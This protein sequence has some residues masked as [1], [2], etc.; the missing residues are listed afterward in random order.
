[1]VERNDPA[2]SELWAESIRSSLQFVRAIHADSD[3]SESPAT[4]VCRI[5]TSLLSTAEVQTCLKDIGVFAAELRS[6]LGEPFDQ[7]E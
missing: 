3:A 5:L 1:M 2:A 6:N 7:A 4:T